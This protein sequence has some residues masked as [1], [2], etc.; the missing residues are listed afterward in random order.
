MMENN[1]E[2]AKQFLTLHGWTQNELQFWDHPAFILSES[3][4]TPGA[5]TDFVERL[6][7]RGICS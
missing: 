7:E 5:A 1:D 6:Q 3:F 2:L 4:D